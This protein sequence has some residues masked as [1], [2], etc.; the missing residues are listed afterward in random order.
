MLG[1]EPL[2]VPL[3]LP[4]VYG[5][6]ADDALDVAE[7]TGGHS[8]V[9]VGATAVRSVEDLRHA[10]RQALG[11]EEYSK[12]A[13]QLEGLS[14][15]SLEELLAGFSDGSGSGGAAAA[16]TAGHLQA[17]AGAHVSSGPASESARTPAELL[18]LIRLAVGEEAFADM[19]PQLEG[20][21]ASQL[22]ELW[23]SMPAPDAA[24][25]PAQ[26]GIG[27][28][29][30]G[31]ASAPPTVPPVDLT[32]ISSARA[33][34]LRGLIRQNLG[35][36]QYTKHSAQLVELGVESLEDLL[37]SLTS[38]DAGEAGGGGEGDTIERPRT[39]EDLAR[40]PARELT[41]EVMVKATTKKAK[42]GETQ[43]Q[44]LS[45]VTHLQ[46]AEK[47]LTA[48]GDL[49]H[50]CAALKVLYLSENR[51]HS[52]GPLP[53]GLESAFLQDNQI[54]QMG[55]WTQRLPQLQILNLNDN[56][57]SLVEGLG[58][59]RQLRELFVRRQRLPSG[60]C[61]NFAPGT[62]HTIADSLQVLD[63]AENALTDLT[64][65]ACLQGLQR[66]DASHNALASVSAVTPVLQNA[67]RLH[68]LKLEGNPFCAVGRYRD[69]VVLHS[70]SL[71]ELDGKEIGSRE[72]VFVQEIAQRRRQRSQ[73][74]KRTPSAPPH[75]DGGG[76]AA[77]NSPRSGGQRHRTGASESP[78]NRC[79]SGA[80]AG[81]RRS[82]SGEGRPPSGAAPQ[83]AGMVG[84]GAPG[85]AL[86][87]AAKGDE[88]SSLPRLPPLLPGA[89]GAGA[90]PMLK[91]DHGALAARR[92]Q[93]Q[94]D[95]A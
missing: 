90:S 44:L 86:R 47:K 11:E 76:S 52:I 61:L 48:L 72:R 57:L 59:C 43:Q 26:C 32:G 29:P 31:S 73:S 14:A 18:D 39:P 51:L 10:V 95:V 85:R 13:E 91:A 20:L 60:C 70:H 17:D 54:W 30:A 1:D 79:P 68:G 58:Q 36:E 94:I 64:P 55:T 63:V 46:L 74:R 9:E 56:R 7:A 38:G 37:E 45:R 22:E 34:E 19:W 28:S 84:G 16:E 66:L 21:Q 65:L 33:E 12:H 15:E 77:G 42:K 4:E 89:A 75:P 83:E 25:A 81:S 88:S 62:L 35:E 53:A 6:L 40:I 87:R 24:A 82:F 23:V 50:R 3:G 80:S 49:V 2:P 41:L 27:A 92:G 71:Q 67:S 93:R 78:R 5:P 69:E 8:G